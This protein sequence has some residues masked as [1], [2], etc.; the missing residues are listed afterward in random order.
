MLKKVSSTIFGTDNTQLR[1]FSGGTGENWFGPSKRHKCTSFSCF[2]TNYSL[3]LLRKDLI[4]TVY[5]NDGYLSKKRKKK[6]NKQNGLFMGSVLFLTCPIKLVCSVWSSFVFIAE[7]T[8]KMDLQT[9]NGKTLLVASG[10]SSS[11]PVPTTNTLLCPYV[12]LLLCNAQPSGE[13]HLFVPLHLWGHYIDLHEF[14]GDLTLLKLDFCQCVNFIKG[15]LTKT[16]CIFVVFFLFVTYGGL[17][18]P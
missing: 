3:Y 5:F 14:I 10:S 7:L 15:W 13:Q 6:N 17:C 4:Y 2:T 8:S 18:Q 12:N 11:G 16:Q 9:L 1:F